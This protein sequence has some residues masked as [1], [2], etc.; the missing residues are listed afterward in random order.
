ME[1]KWE[2]IFFE[3]PRGEKVVK[4]FIKSLDEKA[5][6]KISSDIDLLEK[7]G[8]ILGMPYSKKLTKALYELRI[9]GKQE[10]R[11]IYGFI[12]KS[13]YLLHAFQKKTPKT[14]PK[15]IGIADKRFQGLK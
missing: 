6:S 13:I 12:N 5:I 8:P 7:H 10:I 4:E 11:I 14:P 1:D 15:E 2:I 9:R 3:T